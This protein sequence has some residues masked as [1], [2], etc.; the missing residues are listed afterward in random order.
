MKK[1]VRVSAP[2]AGLDRS[3][4]FQNQPPYT[5]P[6]AMNAWP[7]TSPDG[8]TRLG[9]RPGMKRFHYLD[10]SGAINM[11][12]QVSVVESTLLRNFDELILSHDPEE[13]WVT[14][15]AGFVEPTRDALEPIWYH[16]YDATD[17]TAG[18]VRSTLSQDTAET[19][20]F[21]MMAVPYNGKHAA[22]YRVYF[23]L[24]DTTP[25]PSTTSVYATVTLSTNSSGNDVAAWSVT[26][27]SASTPTVVASGTS[28]RTGHDIRW[29]RVVLVPGSNQCQIQ[30]DQKASLTTGG[31]TSAPASAGTRIGWSMQPTG[32]G[33]RASVSRIHFYY[34]RGAGAEQPIEYHRTILG[35]NGEIHDEQFGYTEEV[36]SNYSILGDL[37][38]MGASRIDKFYIADYGD[39]LYE[40]TNANIGSTAGPPYNWRL[41]SNP[42]VNLAALGIDTYNFVVEIVSWSNITHIDYVP[43]GTYS[44][45]FGTASVANDYVQLVRQTTSAVVGGTAHI[46]IRRCPKVYSQGALSKLQADSDSIKTESST[47][48]VPVGCNIVWEYRDRLGFADATTWY[49]SR[50]GDPLDWAYGISPDDPSAAYASTLGEVGGPAEHIRAVIPYGDDILLI[51]SAYKIYRMIGDIPFGGRIGV[52][53]RFC[54]IVGPEAWCAMPDNTLV[55]LSQDGLYQMSPMA[56]A[57]P[58]ELSRNRLPAE[59]RNLAP[60]GAYPILRYDPNFDLIHIWLSGRNAESGFYKWIFD[61]K[62]KSFWPERWP[63]DW[64]PLAAC[65]A[66]GFF[67]TARP[68]LIGCRDGAVRYYD[69]MARTDDD[70][71]I[72]SWA[73]VGPI[74]GSSEFNRDTVLDK[75][76]IQMGDRSELCRLGVFGG[77]TPDKTV[78]A[79]ISDDPAYEKHIRSGLTSSVHPLVRGN[80]Y[81]VRVSDYDG[82]K[83]LLDEMMLTSEDR[84]PSFDG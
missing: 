1:T 12:G 55:F 77:K 34:K 39:I 19:I 50:L 7:H 22:T 59:F 82:S 64:E 15:V 60:G 47:S 56:D 18:F 3:A 66:R 28:T 20:Y 70:N 21:N 74:R 8:R 41:I 65:N 71:D 48:F 58:L 61:W 67:Y 14:N 53:S 38:V 35:A 76:A 49:M 63:A 52:A 46:R 51:A 32:I 2:L 26:K 68:V 57:S 75:I 5:T 4:G 17:T 9:T 36:D 40:D 27:V 24:D 84:G 83:W 45:T 42:N 29:I 78:R 37:P 44:F 30:I 69:P 16:D 11:M 54:G 79:C 72:S 31:Y 73:S 10:K 23:F 25:S 43:Y 33:D 80:S 62:T 6:D 81:C 13:R